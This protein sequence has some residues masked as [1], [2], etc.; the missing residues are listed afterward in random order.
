MSLNMIKGHIKI[1]SHI[2]PTTFIYYAIDNII[3]NG[4]WYDIMVSYVSG[5]TGFIFTNGE[6]I[7]VCFAR[8]GEKEIPEILVQQVGQDQLVQ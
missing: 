1:E 6:G 3:D 5:D 2:D 7:D 4:S 8:T